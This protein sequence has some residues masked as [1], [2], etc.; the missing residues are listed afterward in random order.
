MDYNSN[1][2]YRQPP[3]PTPPVSSKNSMGKT[4]GKCVLI[5][6]IFGLVA[7]GV[8]TGVSF[9]GQKL[10]ALGQPQTEQTESTR[11]RST[12]TETK[13]ES[14]DDNDVKLEQTSMGE[15]V[16][17]TDVSGV[18]DSVMPSIVA[19]TNISTETYYSFWDGLYSSESESCGSGIIIDQDDEYIYIVSNNHVVADADELK[20]Q[21][22]DGSIVEA[23][24]QGAVPENDLAVVKV[25]LDDISSETLDQIKLAAIGDSSVI[26]VGEPSIAIGNAL[27]YGQSVT[28]G[29]ISALGRSM[30]VE[31]AY[32]ELITNSNLI[33]TDA[34]INPGNS[35]GALLNV[36]GEVIGIN[37]VKYA[38]TDVEG[39]GY[40][41]PMNDAME[42]IEELILQGEVTSTAKGAYLGIQGEDIT[43]DMA[44]VY[45]YPQG[46]RVYR[47]VVGSPAETAGISEGDIITAVDGESIHTM[48][49]LKDLLSD[50][51]EGDTVTI[52]I[53]RLNGEY[54]EMEILVTLGSP[55]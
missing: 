49:E 43:S 26:R 8:F 54:E 9:V 19:I 23:E 6:L 47:V 10:I 51:S 27:G 44:A 24:L 29:V 52:T 1:H 12:K 31:D 22:V 30:V 28:T 18:V 53:Y 21:F 35:G 3:T 48:S 41:I 15:A 14:N 34:A 7:G 13:K 4:I 25:S 2:Y 16:E 40:A 17:L 32:G 33:Q 11:E 37:S 39:M 55:H 45:E 42:I 20:I 46:V 38:S 5:A 36:K 50:Y